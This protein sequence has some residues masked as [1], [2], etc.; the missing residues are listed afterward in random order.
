MLVNP[1]SFDYYETQSVTRLELHLRTWVAVLEQICFTQMRLSKELRDGIYDSLPRFAEIHRK[2]TQ[3][4]QEGIGNKYISNF[5]QFNQF[6]INKEDEDI[7]KKR[8]YN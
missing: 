8:N 5:N 2:T 1:E 3:V 4:M 6:Q 7:I